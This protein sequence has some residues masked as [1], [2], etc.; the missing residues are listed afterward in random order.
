M[1][2]LLAA[3]ALLAA[4]AGTARAA[5]QFENKQLGIALAAPEGFVAAPD[6]GKRDD[7]L[8]EP[9]ALYVPPD[10]EKTAAGLLVHHMDLPGGI[11]YPTFKTAL[12][13][14]LKGAF[15]TSF[16]LVKQED[17]KVDGLTGF[18]LEFECA[19]DGKKPLPGGSEQHHARWY[20]VR[21]GDAKLVGLL[22]TS[23]EPAWKD[24][25][26]KVAASARS[27]KAIGN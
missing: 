13:E 17:L 25:D 11:D 23:R 12:A 15:G 4:A 21:Q 8:G 18:M 14:F 22:Y 1:K 3:F 16:K 9:K 7:F 27:L 26:P 24:I 2:R 5:E 19:G 10:V 6:P 20:L